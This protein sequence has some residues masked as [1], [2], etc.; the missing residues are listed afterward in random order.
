MNNKFCSSFLFSFFL[1]SFSFAQPAITVEEVVQIAIQKNFDIKVAQTT[2]ATQFT[3]KRFIYGAF[4]P[5]I[6]ATG[7]HIENSNNSLIKFFPSS[8]RPDVNVS[9]AASHVNNAGLQ[10]AWTIFDG[11]KM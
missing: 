2:A 1:F 11:T 6:N 8:N 7:A 3:D 5:I 9:S 10:L 4:L